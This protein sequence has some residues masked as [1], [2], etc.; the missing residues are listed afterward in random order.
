MSLGVLGGSGDLVEDGEGV[1]TGE[2]EKDSLMN[3]DL[4]GGDGGG[5]GRLGDWDG[6]AGGMGGGLPSIVLGLGFDIF[7]GGGGA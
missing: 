7:L 5:F 1:L 4:G 6:P 2:S 3:E